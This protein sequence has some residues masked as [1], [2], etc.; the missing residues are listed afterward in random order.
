MTRSTPFG[1]ERNRDSHQPNR[2]RLIAALAAGSLYSIGG[3]RVKAAEAEIAATTCTNTVNWPQWQTFLEHFVQPDGRV[4]DASTPAQHSSS[5]GQSY[6]MFFALIA[7]D[8]STFER[9]WRWAVNNLA[10]GDIRRNLPAWIWGQDAQGQW[11]VL[12]DNSAAD[13]ELWFVYALLEAGKRWHRPDYTDEGMALLQ[14]VE[15]LEVDTLPGLGKMLLPGPR[16]FVLPENTWRLNPSYMPLPVLRRLAS[17][18]PRGPWN[19]IADNTAQMLQ[20]ISPKGFA[21][22]W[23]CYRTDAARETGRFIADPD[24]GDIGSYDAI[25]VYLWAGLT[26][27]DDPLATKVLRSLHGMA[28]AVQQTGAPPEIVNTETG[29]YKNS[30][31]AGFSSAV[32]PYFY[33]LNNASQMRAQYNRSASLLQARITEMRAQSQQP[34][35]YDHVLNLFSTGW[36]RGHYRFQ[37]SGDLQLQWDQTCPPAITQ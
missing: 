26:A 32:V 19:E 16:H 34:P 1:L 13:A 4:L 33:A 9:L 20:A 7:N 5:E 28:K 25:R 17:A 22:D 8:P 11:Q 6:G 3:A 31:P 14:Q 30:G 10:G 35:Y 23:V 29:Q 27:P 12:D 36:Q 37:A 15:T 24:K 21:P 18:S 2:R